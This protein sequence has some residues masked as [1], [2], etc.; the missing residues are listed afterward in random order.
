MSIEKFQPSYNIY[1]ER[2]LRL[3]SIFP[4]A[5][6]DGKVNWEILKECLGD[7]VEDEDSSTEHYSF[8]WP[9]KKDARRLSGKPPQG[10]LIP[11]KGEGVEE[12]NTENLF[13]EGD[14]LEVLKLLQK[15]YAGRIKMMYIDPPYNTG[16]DFIYNDNFTQ[17][18]EEYLKL[19]G[20]IDAEGTPLVSNKKASGRFHTKWLNMMYPRLLLAR[21]LL[22]DDGVIFMSID[23]NEVDNLKKICNEI[24]G[25]ENFVAQL[26]AITNRG[27]RD[28]GG[29]ARTHE[30][31]LIYQR[32]ENNILNEVPKT[33]YKFPFE[34]SLGG[35]EARELRNR[36][37]RFNVNN[38]PNLF[39]PFYVNTSVTDKYGFYQISLEKTKEFCI[40]VCPKK[41]Q[42]VQTVWRWG[43]E[44][45]QLN[46]NTNIIAKQIYNGAFQIIEKYRKST[47]M[48][49]S[50]LDDKEI[51]TERGTEVLKGLFKN[52]GLI[53]DYPKSHKLLKYLL[54]IGSSEESIILDFFAGS[55]TTAHAVLDLNKEDGGNRKFIMVQVPEPCEEDSEA[56]KAG[57]KNIAEIGKERIRR[58]IK[59][60]KEENKPEEDQD[61][62]FKVF[63]LQKSHFKEWQDYEGTDIGEL[64]ELFSKQEDSLTEGWKKENLIVEVILQEGFPLHSKIEKLKDITTN[65]VQKVTCEFCEHSLFI[66]LDDEIKQEAIDKLPISDKDIF[67]CL[68]RALTDE[69]KVRLSDKKIIKT[70]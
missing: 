66:S 42:G 43:K 56:Y 21:N 13:I 23:D 58:V 15:S 64:I 17:P 41:S 29:I 1:P 3:K 25:E 53:Y 36:N 14:N 26:C 38:R 44:K 48:L 46:L 70:I 24:F 50:V 35:F 63:K 7:F 27:G 11:A 68:D 4:E 62:G 16:N 67:I 34:D 39:Y 22:R 59:K 51:V 9:G 8:T 55:A 54:H 18:L 31:I 32:T 49:R 57:Y 20:Q 12:E 19:T 61:L 6:T 52:F 33:D 28:Y 2:L 40:E 47:K 45:S 60:I 10:T 65:V 30:Y 37:I 5:F 69:Q